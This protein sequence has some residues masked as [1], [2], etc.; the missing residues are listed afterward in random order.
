MAW[1]YKGNHHEQQQK[2]CQFGLKTNNYNNIVF[3]IFI[4]KYI[5]LLI[6]NSYFTQ[7]LTK[8]GRQTNWSRYSQQKWTFSIHWSVKCPFCLPPH[9][10]TDAHGNQPFKLLNVNPREWPD[11]GLRCGWVWGT[12]MGFYFKKFII[13]NK[14]LQLEYCIE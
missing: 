7:R 14:I 6:Y 11:I 9:H 4:F 5:S 10:H 2:V 13:I 12:I 8:Q 1:Y 3:S